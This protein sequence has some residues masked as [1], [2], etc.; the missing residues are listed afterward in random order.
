VNDAREKHKGLHRGLLAA[1]SLQ[2]PIEV[3]LGKFDGVALASA[4]VF[5]AGWMLVLLAAELIGA[6]SARYRLRA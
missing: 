5:Q 6:I 2:A 3:L 4:L 1:G